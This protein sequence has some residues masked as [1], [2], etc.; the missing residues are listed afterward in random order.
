MSKWMGRPL[1]IK[2]LTLLHLT[3]GTFLLVQFSRALASGDLPARA[4]A[5]SRNGLLAAA[6]FV[7]VL[8]LASA[9]GMIAGRP[10]G[11]WVGASCYVYGMVRAIEVLGTMANRMNR[12]HVPLDVDTARVFFQPLGMA[13]MNLGIMVYLFKPHVLNAFSI[14][15]S[16][17]RTLVL[18]LSMIGL[19]MVAVGGMVRLIP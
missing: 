10:W 8:L 12:Y 15:P 9:A 7:V 2:L 14:P 18:R 5:I 1:G 6:F 17:S 13:L 11:W 4:L 19:A 3:L 16:R